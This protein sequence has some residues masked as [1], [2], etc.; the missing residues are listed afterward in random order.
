MRTWS[1]GILRR[2]FSLVLS[3]LHLL[4]V[5]MAT[6]FK[7]RTALQ[8]ENIALRHQL[9]VLRRSVKRP[10]LTSADRL[11]WAWLCETWSDWRSF[12]VVVKPETVIGWHRKGFRL[13]W[14][15]KVRRGQS[16][17]PPVSNEIRQLIRRMSRDNP[18][19]GA[20]R[21]HGELLKLGID[22]GETSVGKYLVRRRN[23]PSQTWKTFLENHIQSMVSIDFFTVPTIRFQVLYVFLVLAHDRRRILH[24]NVTRHPTA[25]WT[26]Q[27]LREA[28]SFGQIP[29]YLLRDRDS[30]FGGDFREGVKAMGM[31]EVLSAPRSPWQRAY[32]ERVIGTIR[33]E[34]LDHV[35]VFNEA[36][37]HR[38]VKSFLAYYHESRTHL[39]LAKD[40]PETR[41][42]Q[43]ADAG[44]IVAIPQ[45]GG[46]HHRYE[47]RAA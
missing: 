44:R 34:C 13:F 16:G 46:M 30:I 18:L 37:L 19:W 10:K 29:R 8:V 4:T 12:L 11:L 27:Q 36:S 33:R 43:T 17:R 25:E 21:M 14:T 2:V 35:I 47:R 6:T 1:L 20:P 31:K 38:H 23:P 5:A 28:F 45:V 32:V 3:A 40:P 24:F 7:S 41:A 22:I 26:V 39:S 42:V 15:W 9:A